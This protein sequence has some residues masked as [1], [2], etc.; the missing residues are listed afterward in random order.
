MAI[1]DLGIMVSQKR[2]S[3]GIRAAAA[4]IGIG[5]ATLSRIENGKLPDVGT[6]SKIC[7]WLDVD[8][9]HFVGNVQ[10]RGGDKGAAVQ[11]AFK[12]DTAISIATTESLGVLIL[13]SRDQF[14]S[15]VTENE[16]VGH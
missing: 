9:S 4:E 5:S 10:N 8:S 12:K 14:L 11:I 16:A 1:E 7:D 15:S 6:L 2:G 3:M 13:K